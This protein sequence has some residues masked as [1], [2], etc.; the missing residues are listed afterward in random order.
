MLITPQWVLQRNQ[1]VIY[2]VGAFQSY[3]FLLKREKRKETQAIYPQLMSDQTDYLEE[4]RRTNKN[5]LSVSQKTHKPNQ[6]AISLL[7]TPG[8]P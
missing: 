2:Y 5:I 6:N 3:P 8:G 4:D 7:D 1:K